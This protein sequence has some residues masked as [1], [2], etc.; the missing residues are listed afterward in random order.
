MTTM[1]DLTLPYPINP[2][3]QFFFNCLDSDRMN[4]NFDFVFQELLTKMKNQRCHI[5]AP[6]S[7]NDIRISDCYSIS[8]NNA[9]MFDGF[10]G[11]V[12]SGPFSSSSI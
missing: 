3:F 8:K 6:R 2:I 9:Q 10:I 5:T 1:A 11:R 4:G 12:A 7:P